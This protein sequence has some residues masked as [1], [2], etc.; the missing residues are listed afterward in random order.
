MAPRKGRQDHANPVA[1]PI[2]VLVRELSHR[3][4]ISVDTFIASDPALN[5]VLALA[6]STFTTVLDVRCAQ[7]YFAVA[8]KP[9]STY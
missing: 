9:S 1:L 6:K 7:S 5:A 2:G 4:L 3:Y 8:A